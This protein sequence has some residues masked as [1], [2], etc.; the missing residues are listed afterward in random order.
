MSAARICTA[1]DLLANT[2]SPPESSPL[3]SPTQNSGRRPSLGSESHFA[4]ADEG[5]PAPLPP[6]SK[7]SQREKHHASKSLRLLI[8]G[9]GISGTN[10]DKLQVFHDEIGTKKQH[11]EFFE[12]WIQ[13]DPD[14]YGEAKFT[15]FQSLLTRLEAETNVH[16]TQSSKITSMLVDRETGCMMI[17]DVIE[18]IWPQFGP[19]ERAQIWDDIEE[20]QEKR[21]RNCVKEPPLLPPD[22]RMALERVFRDLDCERKGYV[23]FETLAAARDVCDLPV[24]DPDRLKTYEAEWDI[25]WGPLGAENAGNGTNGDSVISV[26]RK[27]SHVLNKVITLKSF[28][29]MMCPA[30]FRAFEDAEVSTHET[31]SVLIRSSSGKWHA[32]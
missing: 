31:G 32:V 9:K 13:L 19:E 4:L 8:F 22:D 16:R 25:W 26:V 15:E 29:L 17:D 14:M 30:G 6:R 2:W 18:L 21:R 23:F 3:P 7:A 28:L 10:R 1:S 24:I 20:E 11:V 27:G 12:F 5:C